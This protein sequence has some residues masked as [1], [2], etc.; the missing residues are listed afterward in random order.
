MNTSFIL[1]GI[2]GLSGAPRPP[3]RRSYETKVLPKQFN[4]PLICFFWANG[5]CAKNADQCFY[6]HEH[7]PDGVVAEAPV[8]IGGRKCIHIS[9]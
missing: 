5:G 4:P 9:S 2:P 3:V 1:H 8:T 6:L 7:T